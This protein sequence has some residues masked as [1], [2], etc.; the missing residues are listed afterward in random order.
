MR[1]VVPISLGTYLAVSVLVAMT[2]VATVYAAV[3]IA[4]CLGCVILLFTDPKK[5][6][7]I[8]GTAL[9]W[10]LVRAYPVALIALIA[11]LIWGAMSKKDDAG[12]A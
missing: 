11:L 12:L 9:L 3:L 5:L 4:I 6:L 10:G 8:I 2:A 1:L 7:A